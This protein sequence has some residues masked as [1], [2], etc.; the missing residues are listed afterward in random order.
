MSFQSK[1]YDLLVIGGGI[2]GAAIVHLAA[3]AGARVALVEKNDWASGTSSKSTKLLHGGIRYLENFEFDLVAESLKERYI[4]WKSAPHLVKPM[5]FIIPVYRGQGRPLWEMELGVWLYDVLS[6]GYSV[7]G[8]GSLSIQEVIHLIPNLK[9]MGLK[10]AVS[11][12][13]AQ[14]DDARICLENVLMAKKYGAD[15][16]NYTEAIEYIK[17]DGRAI[18][19]RVRGTQGGPVD[20]MANKIVVAAGPWS[21]EM[22]HKDSPSLKNALRV[23]KGVHLIC[24]GN[25][26]QDAILLQ[27]NKDGRIFFMIPF[28]DNVLIGTTDTDYTLTKDEVHVLPEDVDYLL[29]QA[30]QYF[31]EGSF[32]KESIISTYAGLRPLVFEA[33]NPSQ[34]SR[35]H[36]LKKEMSGV[37]YVMGGKY[38]T[39]RAIAVDCLVNVMPQLDRGLYD[40]N[41]FELYGSYLKPLDVKATALR[42]GVEPSIIN[43][44]MSVYGSRYED[45]LFLCVDDPTLKERLCTCSLS[46]RAQ[47]KYAL[48][49]EMAKT[50]D[51]IYIRRLGLSYHECSSRQCRMS[52]A[53]MLGQA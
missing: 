45:V 32:K 52:I 5:R 2:N 12:Y 25:I 14:M 38:T 4:Q 27:N 8:S 26:G 34:V 28:G 17:K 15:V 48:Q 29:T 19:V 47:V 42:Y 33:K 43:H 37:Y 36:V 16:A 50:V 35:K 10:G 11:Y 40:S 30:A 31:P 13:D 20:I 9:S 44:L 39:Y 22:R 1:T 24:R 6:G 49:V 18:G 41:V 51:D 3:K 23:T 46:I 53:H 7:G 21:D